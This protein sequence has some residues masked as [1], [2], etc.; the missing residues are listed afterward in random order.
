MNATAIH[1]TNSRAARP[2][3]GFTL[4]ELLV[5][6]TIVG[7][8]VGVGLPSYMNVTNSNRVAAEINGLLYDM[9]FARAEAVK[10]GRSVTVC[11]SSDGQTCL[12]WP[13]WGA[14]WIV[15]QDPNGNQTVD[16]GEAVLKSQGALHKYQDSLWPD[17]VF[18]NWRPAITFNR[19]GYAVGLA[20]TLTFHLH[21]NQW[22]NANTRCLQLSIVGQTQTQRFGQ[23]N[24]TW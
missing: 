5:A 24:C 15:F 20:G 17:P 13:W 9:Q 8:L 1:V 23:A 16:A 10:E 3:G 7:I 19:E 2:H 12:G 4:P 14:G 22:N 21:D 6:L 11:A 18:G